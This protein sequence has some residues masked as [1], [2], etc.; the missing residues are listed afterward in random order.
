MP[1]QLRK[2]LRNHFVLSFVPFSREFDDTMK[3]IVN[4]IKMLE[5]G[6]LMN[7][8]GQDMWIIAG[9]GVIT[10]DLCIAVL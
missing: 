3:P 9:L 10:T 8:N 1:L 7:I 4:E 5:K 2:Q 6:V